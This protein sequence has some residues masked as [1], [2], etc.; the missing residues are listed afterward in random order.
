MTGTSAFAKA[1]PDIDFHMSGNV[2]CIAVIG[3]QPPDQLAGLTTDI[4]RVNL[5]SGYGWRRKPRHFKVT[6]ANDGDI[7]R[8]S[9]FLRFEG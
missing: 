9:D 6:E 4:A 7:L 3:Q 2:V 8:H 1:Q 5:D